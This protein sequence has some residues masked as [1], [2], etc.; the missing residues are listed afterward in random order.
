MSDIKFLY[1]IQ[2]YWKKEEKDNYLK[3]FILV[4]RKVVNNPLYSEPDSNFRMNILVV[5]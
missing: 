5:R 1:V 3:N 4:K 2:S